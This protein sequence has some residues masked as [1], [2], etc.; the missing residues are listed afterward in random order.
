MS[1]E[2][3]S[4]ILRSGGYRTRGRRQGARGGAAA[5][6][7]GAGAADGGDPAAAP[8]PTVTQRVRTLCWKLHK[9]HG[10]RVREGLIVLITGHLCACMLLGTQLSASME[11]AMFAFNVVY[12]FDI[13]TDIAGHGWGVYLR[14]DRGPFSAAARRFDFTVVA[15]PTVGLIGEAIARAALDYQSGAV[16]RL[17]LAFPALRV[18]SV[19][20]GNRV[21]V[22][23]LGSMLPGARYPPPLPTHPCTR[24]R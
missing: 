18:F 3:M 11:S 2:H 16:Y 23:G 24:A 12:W 21:L 15:A 8:P 19:P 5:A 4:S 10:D 14:E 13:L 7:A 9:K 22:F 20:K 17:L 6:A 1:L